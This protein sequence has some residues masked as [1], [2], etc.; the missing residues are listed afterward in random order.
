MMWRT[1]VLSAVNAV[2]VLLVFAPIVEMNT[3]L[4]EDALY[5]HDSPSFFLIQVALGIFA[6]IIDMLEKKQHLQ[7]KLLTAAVALAVTSAGV[8]L[9]LALTADQAE[10]FGGVSTVQVGAWL[11]LLNVLLFGIVWF[12][13]RRRVAHSAK[14]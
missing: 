12:D 2:T 10:H 6:V 9:W 8:I 3:V 4:S 13:Q 14:K 11:P 5:L 1:V 7:S